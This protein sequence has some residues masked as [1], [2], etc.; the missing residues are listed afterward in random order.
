VETSDPSFRRRIHRNCYAC[1][2]SL[3]RYCPGWADAHSDR[4]GRADLDRDST[5]DTDCNPNWAPDPDCDGRSDLDCDGY[6][7]SNR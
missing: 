3:V 6:G 2:D 4:D 5:A 1:R 7:N